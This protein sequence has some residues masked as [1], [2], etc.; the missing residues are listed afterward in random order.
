MLISFEVNLPDEFVDASGCFVT[1][2]FLAYARPLIGG[3]LP[4]F[5]PLDRVPPTLAPGR[6]ER[7]S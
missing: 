7:I 2:A 5:F 1:P 6:A 4:K 3:P